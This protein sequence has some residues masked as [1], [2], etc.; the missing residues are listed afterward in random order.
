MMWAC[1]VTDSGF[2]ECS[3]SVLGT[4]L[5]ERFSQVSGSTTSHK[6][7]PTKQ[8]FLIFYYL[9]DPSQ[10]VTLKSELGTIASENKMKD[11]TVIPRLTKIIRSGI[12]FFSRNVIS[13]RFLWKIV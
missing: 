4:S 10:K 12:T 6:T 11:C 2:L 13:R 8:V 7:P 9:K 5:V 1:S 3:C